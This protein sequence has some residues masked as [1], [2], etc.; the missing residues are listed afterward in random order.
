MSTLVLIVLTAAGCSRVPSEQTVRD[1][2]NA[3][4]REESVGNASL[5]VFRKTN[6]I[7][8]GDSAYTMEF[9]TRVMFNVHCYWAVVPGLQPL[10]FRLYKNPPMM[11]HREMGGPNAVVEIDGQALLQKTENGWRVIG[12]SCSKI[13]DQRDINNEL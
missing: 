11:F 2:L 1:I 7:P 4:V 13:T 8:H 10:E 5:G 6:G 9:T 3:K 12:F